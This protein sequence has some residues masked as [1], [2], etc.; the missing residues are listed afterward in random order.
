MEELA[1]AL[2]V[3]EM[4]HIASLLRVNLTDNARALEENPLDLEATIDLK[5]TRSCLIKITLSSLGRHETPDPIKF[6]GRPNLN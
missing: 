4:V 3:D 5:K 6:P 1:I 2:D